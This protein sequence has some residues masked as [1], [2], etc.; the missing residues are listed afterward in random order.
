MSTS[1]PLADIFKFNLWANLQ[2]LDACASLDSAVLEASAPGT[3]GSIRETL[4]HIIAAEEGYVSRFTSQ[5]PERSQRDGDGFPGLDEL[6]RRAIQSG[7]AL[8]AIGESFVPGRV[9]QIRHEGKIHD[10]SAIVVLIQAITH[11]VDHR[12]QVATI[13]SQHGATPPEIDGWAYLDSS[14]NVASGSDA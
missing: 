5:R 11:A 10:V 6:R 9:L 3:L 1:S 2:M 13:L 14:E 7:E 12:S 8:I 4:L